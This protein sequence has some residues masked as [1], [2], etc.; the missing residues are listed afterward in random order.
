LAKNIILRKKDKYWQLYPLLIFC[1]CQLIVLRNVI[2]GLP[3]SVSF[4]MPV[5]H[6]N[7]IHEREAAFA[8]HLE[9]T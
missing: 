8:E 7:W 1:G 3:I 9:N 4:D 5:C 2:R 6:P